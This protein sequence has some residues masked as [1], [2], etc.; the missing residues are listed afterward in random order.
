MVAVT[1]SFQCHAL[2]SSL[3]TLHLKPQSSSVVVVEALCDNICGRGLEEYV[4][5]GTSLEN[6][7]AWYDT[8]C[9]PVKR[10]WQTAVHLSIHSA[11]TPALQ[12]LLLSRNGENHLPLSVEWHYGIFYEYFRA[13]PTK[14]FGGV[15]IFLHTSIVSCRKGL[16]VSKDAKKCVK[17]RE[18]ES[19]W[20]LTG[21]WNNFRGD[22]LDSSLQIFRRLNAANANSYLVWPSLAPLVP[23]AQ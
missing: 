8:Y 21:T 12:S 4:W 22:Y 1:N 17:V 18:A 13:L 2:S 19:R 15:F 3:G 10:G 23:D 7:I 20:I 5:I 9:H 14:P 6:D 16:H 11:Y